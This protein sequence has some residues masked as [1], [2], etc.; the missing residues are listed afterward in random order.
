MDRPL[1]MAVAGDQ[2]V[3]REK[4]AEWLVTFGHQEAVVAAGQ[5]QMT[6]LDGLAAAE[7]RRRSRPKPVVPLSDSWNPAEV[8]RASTLGAGWLDKPF[9]RHD[10][11]PAVDALPP[12]RPARRVLVVDDDADT[13]DSLAQLLELLGCQART[14]AD[15][16]QAVEVAEVFLPD[17]ILMDLSMS[18][19]GGLAAVR[20]I[21]AT[22]GGRSIRIAAHTGWTN[23]ETHAR[24]A[25][26]DDYLVKPVE[27]G[28]LQQLLD[29][30]PVPVD[31]TAAADGVR[32]GMACRTR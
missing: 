2:G 11:M 18:R 25:G 23:Q 12:G 4:R 27:L 31:N 14:A 19:M 17:L 10:L 5:P 28:A 7:V 30:L 20:R 13:V 3:I 6:H 16:L 22:D 15:G 26:C 9:R 1:K 29:E 32:F 8:E 21:R 24:E